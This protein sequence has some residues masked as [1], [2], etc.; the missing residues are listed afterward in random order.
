MLEI[1]KMILRRLEKELRVKTRDAARNA[2]NEIALLQLN[3]IYQQ[4]KSNCMGLPNKI[5][6][7]SWNQPGGAKLIPDTTTSNDSDCKKMLLS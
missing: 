6:G 4:E 5:A 3:C 1:G 7:K 2:L